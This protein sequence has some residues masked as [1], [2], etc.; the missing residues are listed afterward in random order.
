MKESG[1]NIL[2]AVTIIVVASLLLVA[3]MGGQESVRDSA[4]Y[5]LGKHLISLHAMHCHNIPKGDKEAYKACIDGVESQVLQKY[6][7]PQ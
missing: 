6:G 7:V 3:R 2:I 1:R 4:A 5:R